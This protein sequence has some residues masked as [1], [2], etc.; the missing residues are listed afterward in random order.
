VLAIGL[1]APP[2]HLPLWPATL[3][4]HV[5]VAPGASASATWHDELVAS[6]LEIRLPWVSLARMLTLCGCVCIGVAM[7]RTAREGLRSV[8]QRDFPSADYRASVA[9][10]GHA[11]MHAAGVATGLGDAADS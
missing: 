1:F 2:N 4:A 3:P 11:A 10:L 9:L 7:V 6:G 8:D 5:A